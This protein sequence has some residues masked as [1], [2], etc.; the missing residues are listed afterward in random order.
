MPEGDVCTNDPEGCCSGLDCIGSVNKVCTD[1][2]EEEESCYQDSDCCNR[3]CDGNGGTTCGCPDGFEWNEQFGNCEY[4]ATE[5]YFTNECQYDPFNAGDSFVLW[6]GTPGCFTNIFGGS[7]GQNPY[8]YACCPID[9][10]QGYPAIYGWQDIE[11][12]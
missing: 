4:V 11:V 1:C 8:Y 3:P 12:Y 6:L 9:P 7:P 2:L 10:G 5:C